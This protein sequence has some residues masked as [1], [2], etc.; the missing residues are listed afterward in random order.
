MRQRLTQYF[1][2]FDFHRTAWRVATA[3]LLVQLSGCFLDPQQPKVQY[4]PDMADAPTV[5]AQEDYLDPPVGAIALTSPLYPKTIEEAEK[6]L[7]MPPRIA[8]DPET[9]AK[10]EVL[11]DTFCIPCHGKDAKGAGSIISAGFP[12]PPDIT[13]ATYAAKTDGF[14]FYRI[15]FGSA[16][17][18]MPGYGYAT[19]VPERWQIV[20]YLRTLQKAGH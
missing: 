18:V 9:V 2:Y 14:F 12:Q 19:A 11:F 17:G 13:H 10:G 8:A 20:S 3:A 6:V 7:T 16:N 4:M 1:D 15:T 5:K